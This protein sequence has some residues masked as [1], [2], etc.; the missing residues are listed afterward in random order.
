[1]ARPVVGGGRSKKVALY[2]SKNATVTF[3]GNP[4]AALAQFQTYVQEE[5]L[6]SSAR[7]GILE[8]YNQ[9]RQNIIS[10]RLI[11]SG[12]LLDSIYHWH[13][14]KQSKLDR[15]VY[16]TGPN[17]KVAPHWF[18]VEYGNRRAPAHPYFR[19]AVTAKA[20]AALDRVKERIKEKLAEFR[21]L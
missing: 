6:R 9:I 11:D 8:V 15:Q 18:N 21:P 10:S 13:N 4:R 19:P 20:R 3:T 12:K 14:F 17:K 1:M 2:S 16:E 7:Q 5:V